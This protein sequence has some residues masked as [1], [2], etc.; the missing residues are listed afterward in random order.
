MV[1]PHQAQG[2]LGTWISGTEVYVISTKMQI[3]ASKT[4]PTIMRE[5]SSGA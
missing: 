5:I 3:V 1:P 4:G 2:P